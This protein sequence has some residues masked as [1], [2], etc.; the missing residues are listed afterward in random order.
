MRSRRQCW[1]ALLV[2]PEG[3]DVRSAVS[4]EVLLRDPAVAVGAACQQ[5]PDTKGVLG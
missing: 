5:Q 3:I 1:G 4:V 2:V